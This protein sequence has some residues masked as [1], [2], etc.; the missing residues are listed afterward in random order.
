MS[1]VENNVKS[2]SVDT[3][4]KVCNAIGVNAGDVMN[5]MGNQERLVVIRKREW[6]DVD[7]PHTGFST[8]RFFQP[9]N[10]TIIDSAIIVLLPNK[11]IPVRKD[12]NNGQELLCIL[13]GSLELVRIN[14][15]ITLNEGDVVHYWSDKE[16]QKIVNPNNKQ[17]IAL[18]IGTL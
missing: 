8:R 7:L 5:Q 9:E 14:E 12:I 13:K 18:W 17:A 1:Q 4:M 6:E 15:T 10:R 16:K 11:S 2:P 3:L